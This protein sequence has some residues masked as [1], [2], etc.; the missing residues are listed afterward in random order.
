MLL[1]SFAFIFSVSSSFLLLP[2]SLLFLVHSQGGYAAYRYAQPTAVAT[3][4]AAAA[5]AAAAYSDRSVNFT[6]FMSV[7]SQDCEQQ[8]SATPSVSPGEARL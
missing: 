2:I 4:A 8:L 7:T 3:P 6:F 1:S 5:A